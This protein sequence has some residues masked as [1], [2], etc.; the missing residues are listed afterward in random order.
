[1]RPP[2]IVNFERLFLAAMALGVICVVVGYEAATAQLARES[3]LRQLGIGGSEM[4]IGISAAW[5]A[6]FLVLWFLIAR[7][8]LNAA[9][10]TLVI[11]AAIGAVFF[12]PALTGRWDLA[13]LLDV[14]YYA[15]ELA[16]VARLF[17]AD[18]TAW[19]TGKP[20]TGQAAL[21]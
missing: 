19:L 12:L 14:A 6:I 9:K 10:W 3:A 7:K 16:A 20:D 11:L 2:S 18:A 17:R 13:L 21:D 5:L 1:M 8:A 15:L 4:Y